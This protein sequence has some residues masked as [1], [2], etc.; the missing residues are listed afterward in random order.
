[1]KNKDEFRKG[2]EQCMITHVTPTTKN[3]IPAG[4]IGYNCAELEA[5][6]VQ[7]NPHLPVEIIRDYIM[8]ANQVRT[9]IGNRLDTAVAEAKVLYENLNNKSI[10]E[11]EQYIKEN[12]P[13]PSAILGMIYAVVSQKNSKA[14]KASRAKNLHRLTVITAMRPSRQK[15]ESLDTFLESL[16]A[17]S[18]ENLTAEQTDDGKGKG[19]TYDITCDIGNLDI[20]SYKYDALKKMWTDAGKVTGN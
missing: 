2:V 9:D 1:M 19:F 3:G 10:V 5:V 13:S 18:I 7:R 17:S 6:L 12:P 15:S 16:T 11:S 20:R 14:A 8:E 4:E